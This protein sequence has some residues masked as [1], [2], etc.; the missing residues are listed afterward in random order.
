MDIEFIPIAFGVRIDD[1]SIPGETGA[2]LQALPLHISRNVAI[3]RE[4]SVRATALGFYARLPMTSQQSHRLAVF[5]KIAVDALGFKSASYVSA[6]RETFSGV[7]I[8]NANLAIGLASSTRDG[9]IRVAVTFGAE[10]DLAFNMNALQSDARIYAE[11]T[12]NFTEFFYVFVRG[13][14]NVALSTT[15]DAQTEM[16]LMSGAGFQF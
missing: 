15:T 13:A 2:A 4:L 5:G 10:G 9:K 1:P 14:Y 16:Q 3:D 12:A 11:L 6:N 8:G 7:A